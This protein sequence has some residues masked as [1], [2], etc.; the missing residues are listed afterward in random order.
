MVDILGV[1]SLLVITILFVLD[2]EWGCRLEILQGLLKEDSQIPKISWSTGVSINENYLGKTSK[3]V[4]K[5]IFYSFLLV[6]WECAMAQAVM[7]N[8]LA[9]TKNIKH[10][11][12]I[13]PWNSIPRFMS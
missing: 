4:F 9:V 6:W 1:C 3:I 5:I 11:I 13:Y 12:A 2:G 8:S 10:R 7:E